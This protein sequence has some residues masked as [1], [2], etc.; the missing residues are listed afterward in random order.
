MRAVTGRCYNNNNHADSRVYEAVKII[1]VKIIF[2]LL[3]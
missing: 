2:E 1:V 3:L